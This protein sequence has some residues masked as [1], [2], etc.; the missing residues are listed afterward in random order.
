MEQPSNLLTSLEPAKGRGDKFGDD[1]TIEESIKSV[2]L[3]SLNDDEVKSLL[4]DLV[5]D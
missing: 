4:I 3:D 2:V 1:I 5:S